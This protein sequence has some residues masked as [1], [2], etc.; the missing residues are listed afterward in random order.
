MGI[1]VYSLLCVMQDLYPQA[2]VQSWGLRVSCSSEA[3]L[4]T[5]AAANDHCDSAE[6]FRV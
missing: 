1:M 4:A 2:Y 5:P 3:A 6:G